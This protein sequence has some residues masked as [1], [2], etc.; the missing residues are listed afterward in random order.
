MVQVPT[1]V[2]GLVV[3]GVYAV[4][5]RLDANN[6]T[7]AAPFAAGSSATAAENAGN[8]LISTQ[9]VNQEPIDYVITPISRTDYAVQPNKAQQARPT[10]V[11]W[12]R[13]IHST[14]TLWPVPDQNGPYVLFYYA[15]VQMDGAALAG[16]ADLDIPYRFLE[17]FTAGL[18]A[19][20]ARKYPPPPPNTI[21][22]LLTEAQLAWAAA[23]E[24]DVERAP[25]YIAPTLSGYFR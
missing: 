16:G 14:V 15:M 2:G 11:W 12:N 17:A 3:S 6:F 20:L 19:K 9:V 18:A 1:A 8:A 24:Q 21:A 13:Q 10:T 4:V 5:A 7:I 25:L 22:D 23:S